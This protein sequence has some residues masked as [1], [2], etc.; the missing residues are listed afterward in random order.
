MTKLYAMK[1]MEAEQAII[2]SAMLDDSWIPESDLAAEDFLNE[3]HRRV[4]G[5]I[6]EMVA[7]NQPIDLVT[8]TV[9]LGRGKEVVNYL[10]D[11]MRN[12]P[13]SANVMSYV[14]ILKRYSAKQKAAIVLANALTEL[15][16][17]DDSVDRT[18]SA[19][20]GLTSKTTRHEHNTKDYLTLA[21]K[22][23]DDMREG[24]I[25]VLSTGLSCLDKKLGGF[26]DSDLIVIA[27]RPAMGK[28]A[29]MLNMALKCGEPVGIISGE[30]PAEQMALRL[31]AMTGR[32][33]VEK[34]RSIQKMQPDDWER[35]AAGFKSLF[36]S[37]KILINDKPMPTMAD[38]QR[39]ARKWKHQDGVKAVFIDYTQRIAGG[40]MRAPKHER[41]GEIVKG[42]KSL[43]RELNIPVIALAQVSRAVETR[44]VKKP[45]MAD[46][47]DSSE[48][49]KEADQVITLYRDEVYNSQSSEKGIIEMIICKNRHGGV[50]FVRAAWLDRFMLAETL[51]SDE[52]R[53]AV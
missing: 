4:W 41:I 49:E 11:M 31:V 33:D 7:L 1:A 13:S 44:N 14:E 39:Q 10:T 52:R 30:Q 38:I 6:L 35:V 40:D 9:R 22:Y 21:N 12:T 17:S 48:I 16:S 2:G 5:H 19:L 26:H 32:V 27:G 53:E 37:N 50:G 34:L 36:D 47:S 28:T 42:L 18:I 25:K 20:M 29:L 24:R 8:M 15:D 43:A 45:G 23:I 51:A 3:T 46:I